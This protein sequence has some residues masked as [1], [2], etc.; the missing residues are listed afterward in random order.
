MPA[1]TLGKREVVTLL[2]AAPGQGAVDR[3]SIQDWRDG[4]LQRQD[5]VSAPQLFCDPPMR[6][7]SEIR[8]NAKRPGC[9]APVGASR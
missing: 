1:G 2:P 8:P 3:F 7:D 4:K 5:T 9:S 6:A